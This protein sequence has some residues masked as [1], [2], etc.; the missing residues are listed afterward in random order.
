MLPSVDLRAGFLGHT[1][2][3]APLALDRDAAGLARVRVDQH[4][5]GDVDRTFHLD[6]PTELLRALGVAQRARA[7]VA[8]DDVRALDVDLLLLRVHTQHAAGPALVL[9]GDDADG[10]VLADLDRHQLE[11]L[12]RERHDLHEV[13]VT[14]LARDGAEDARAARVVGGVDQDRGVLVEGDVGPVVAAELLLGA[15]HHRRHDLALL[16]RAVRDRLLDRADDDVADPGI[17]A[18]RPTAHADAEHLAR[19]GVVGDL[20]PG[21]LLD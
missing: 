21:L 13:A 6:D 12:R 4:H 3:P 5:V 17:A 10:V 18:V 11:H 1:P 19:A 14:Q 15:D 9:A 2:A 20:E 16:D 8:L 7:G